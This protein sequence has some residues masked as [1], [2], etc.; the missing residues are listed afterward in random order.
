MEETALTLTWDQVTGIAL[1]IGL[2]VCIFLVLALVSYTK[3]FCA[4]RDIVLE[5]L[6]VEKAPKALSVPALLFWTVLFLIL[7][8]S[9]ITVIFNV[10][11]NPV[12]LSED[13]ITEQRWL[14]VRMTA[15][16]ATLG[17]VV[18]LPF[19]LIKTRQS[20]RQTRATEE[21]LITDRINNAVEGL[22][23]EKKVDRIGRPVTVVD[24]EGVQ[25]TYIH[26]QGEALPD[27][28]VT[29]KGEWQVF[30]ETRPNLE[31]RIGAILALE[32]LARNN[33]DI[34]VQIMEI[35]CAYIRKNA[36]ADEA[37]HISTFLAPREESSENGSM[38]PNWRTAVSRFQIKLRRE[39]VTV[40]PREDIQVALTVLGRRGSHG[41]L[42][43]ARHNNPDPKA[44]FIFDELGPESLMR[45]ENGSIDSAELRSWKTTR[46]D[47]EGYR[48]DLRGAN[49]QRAYL[50]RLNFS[51]ARFN[52][53]QMQGADLEG[54]Q[55]RGADFFKAQMQG[56][57][58]KGAKMQGAEFKMAAMLGADFRKAQMQ[59][60][61]FILANMQ[62][63]DFRE[64]QMQE[65]NFSTAGMKGADFRKAQ[66][67][68]AD[69]YRAEFDTTTAL[70][71]ADLT[72]AAVKAVD[73]TKIPQT[74]E[75]L[76]GL[77]GD[78]TTQLPDGI[79]APDHWPKFDLAW[80]DFETEW[81]KWKADPDTYVPPDPPSRT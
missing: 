49:L 21:G 7:L 11:S 51:G 75:H 29:E 15:L 26:W 10:I 68:G 40:R 4:L 62:G 18:A 46:E 28:D 42:L 14:L 60:V 78:A 33:L 43:E 63:A 12:P 19:T 67:Q 9:L 20:E 16:V 27:S 36:P 81:K 13:A 73:F 22:G 70:T 50:A 5:K 37:K 23:A 55:M 71:A 76:A 61:Q 38:R 24:D 48:L 77:F 6:G 25:E 2:F 65:A 64:A 47:F 79:D 35:L 3:A 17:A 57:D 74:A 53:T 34:H 52:E 30:S 72:M 66:M 8:F 1:N 44:E 80:R 31:V 56:A 41:R 32:R 58:L 39:L 45:Q 69:L 54:A 59:G